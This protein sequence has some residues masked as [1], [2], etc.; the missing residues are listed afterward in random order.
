MYRKYFLKT[1][2]E[3]LDVDHPSKPHICTKT[4]DNIYIYWEKDTDGSQETTF[5]G[6]LSNYVGKEGKLRERIRTPS[7]RNFYGQNFLQE[8][9]IEPTDFLDYR[10]FVPSRQ[11]L[12]LSVPQPDFVK[13]LPYVDVLSHSVSTL[14]P[15]VGVLSHSVSSFLPY[16]GVLSHSVTSFLPYVGVLSHSVSSFLPYVGVLSHSV[17]SF[18]P[19]VGVL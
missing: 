6:T 3:Y 12:P 14:L 15:Y 18:L 13:T 17:S 16:V 8:V 4:V 1:Y 2:D 10:P 5:M 19:Y 7:T 11:T 9:G